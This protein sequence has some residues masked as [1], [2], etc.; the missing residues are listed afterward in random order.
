MRFKEEFYEV[1][2]TRRS[3]RSF[4]PDPI[5]D[6]VLRK[7]LEAARITPSGSNRQ[8]LRFIIVKNRELIRSIADACRCQGFISEAP[9][10]IVACGQDIKYNRGGYMGSLSMLIDVSIALTHLILAARAERLG[11]CWIGSFSNE[12][13]KK[14]LQIP[15]EWNVVAVTLLG[16]LKEPFSEPRARK[17]LE[18]IVSFD[19]LPASWMI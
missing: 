5:P 14:I 4:K 8:P 2:R 12:E 9:I 10:L 7:V 11:T 16:F 6:D 17:P 13:L 18:E 15:Q 1:I 19:G 3:I